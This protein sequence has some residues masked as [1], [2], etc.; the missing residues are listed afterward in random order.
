[1]KLLGHRNIK[2]TL[3]YTLLIR[4]EDDKKYSSKV[5]KTVNEAKRLVESRFDYVS[6]MEE[7]KLFQKR[8]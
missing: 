3:I 5:S 6:E 1:M 8:K 4:I 2:N 7:L